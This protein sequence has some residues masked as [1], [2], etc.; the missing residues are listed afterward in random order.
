MKDI[1]LQVDDA[2]YRKARIH[3]AQAGTSVSA[4]MRDFLNREK[5]G[6]TAE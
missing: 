3:A 6:D 1:T 5:E 2:T 4:M